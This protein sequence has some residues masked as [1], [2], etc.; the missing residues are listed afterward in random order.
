[1]YGTLEEVNDTIAMLKDPDLVRTN[2]ELEQK[3][4]GK[5]FPPVVGVQKVYD[6]VHNGPHGGL[7]Y[8]Y[9]TTSDD[10]STR[11]PRDRAAYLF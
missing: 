5:S 10:P 1:M 3:N 2:S 6:L 4:K 7:S 9:Y 11:T 8:F